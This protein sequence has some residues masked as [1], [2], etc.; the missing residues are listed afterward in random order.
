MSEDNIFAFYSGNVAL[1]GVFQKV[2]MPTPKTK[3]VRLEHCVARLYL[4]NAF[5]CLRFI[6]LI[7]KPPP[8]KS[9]ELIQQ[10]R[11]CNLLCNWFLK[12]TQVDYKTCFKRTTAVKS[13]SCPSRQ[14]NICSKIECSYFIILMKM[15][16]EKNK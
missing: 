6:S 16:K 7:F 8:P 9:P 10:I 5:Q 1:H 4:T 15:L 13:S 2:Q 3:F 14:M 11:L 12:P